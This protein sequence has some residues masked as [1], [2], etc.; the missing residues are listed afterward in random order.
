MDPFSSKGTMDSLDFLA[1]FS[2]LGP[3]SSCVGEALQE[4]RTYM[5]RSEPGMFFEMEARLGSLSDNG[6][7]SDV[8]QEAFTTL[9]G[10]LESYPRWHHVSGWVESQ[11]V[12]YAINLPTGQDGKSAQA[13]VR[14]TVGLDAEKKIVLNHCIKRKLRVLD[15]RVVTLGSCNESSY[16]PALQETL[17]GPLNPRISFSVEQSVPG[18]LLP[19][20]VVPT[21]VRIKQRKRFFITSLGVERPAFSVDMT[22]VYSGKSKSEAEQLQMAAK[23]AIYEVEVECLEPLAYL[24]S[25]NQQEQMLA[26]SLLLKLHDFV[27]FLNPQTPVT[28]AKAR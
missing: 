22:I 17:V 21:R 28:F 24:Q 26:L 5:Q 4:V 1:E 3:A 2:H 27:S 14:T 18:E 10:M 12:F 23:D 25:C 16:L 6:Y 19:I 7:V 9:L 11:D 20:A 8:G 13:E 15:L